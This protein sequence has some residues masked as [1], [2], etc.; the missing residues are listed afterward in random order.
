MSELISGKGI[1][2]GSRWQLLA[3]V[4][5]AALSVSVVAPHVAL[6]D[7][8]DRPTVWIELGGQMERSNAPSAPF[9]PDFIVKNQYAPHNT[10]SPLSAE[11]PARYGF[12]GEGSISFQPHGSDWI[13]SAAV[14][15]GRSNN[16]KHLHQQT[17]SQFKRYLTGLGTKYLPVTR[18]DDALTTNHETHAVV[19]FK[20]GRDV[21]LGL[22][23]RGSTSNIAFGV[24]Y[25]QFSA[26]ATAVFRSLP[27]PY[28][29][30]NLQNFQVHHH[31]SYYAHQ[32]ISRSFRGVG[33]SISWTG[34]DPIVGNPDTTEI[35]FDW[36]AN[37]AVLFGRQ[38]VLG[39][40]QSTGIYYTGVYNAAVHSQY[41]NNVPVNRS[42]SVVVPN[43]GGL[44]GLSFRRGNAKVSFGYRADFFFGAMD[45]GI[46]T[47]KSLDRNFYGPY[48][49]ISVGLGG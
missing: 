7:D 34:S 43:V 30:T 6:A 29:S 42:H 35:A 8:G 1:R 46:D 24:R 11:Q 44:A 36:G 27:D 25:A 23:G 37:A 26:S 48:A 38:K 47:R 45:G 4:S 2:G 5:V 32:N 12:G 22:F 49:S 19:D 33:P 40:H 10:V 20:A 3:T 21:G 28:Y 39:S 9:A 15:Y 16:G 13:Y 14:R 41:H 18:W 31:H 17:V